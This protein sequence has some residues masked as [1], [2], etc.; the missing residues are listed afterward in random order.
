MEESN[1]IPNEEP[2]R[3]DRPRRTSQRFYRINRRD[4]SFLRFILEAYDGVAVLT[5]QDVRQGIVS[6][7]IAPGCETLVDGI[8][9][10]LAAGE[11]IMIE[12]FAPEDCTTCFQGHACVNST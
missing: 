8:I 10:S 11:D 9:T 12:S 2:D 1:K 3:R 5:T 6:I 4:I 7:A